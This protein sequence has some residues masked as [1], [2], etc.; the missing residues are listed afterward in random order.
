MSMGRIKLNLKLTWESLVIICAELVK[1]I[2]YWISI[3]GDSV[4][5]YRS[6]KKWVKNFKK[7]L[8]K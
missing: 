5:I 8:W 2:R 7:N 4:K 1:V 6:S 3:K